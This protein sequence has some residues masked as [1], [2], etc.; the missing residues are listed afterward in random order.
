MEKELETYLSEVEKRLRSMP[1]SERIDVV[2]EL[3]SCMEELKL[4]EKKSASEIMTQLG[5]A[6]ELARQY[7]SNSISMNT[8]FNFRKLLMVIALYGLTGLSGMFIIPCCTVLA[9]GL[10][11][12]GTIA[13]IAGLIKMVGFILAIDMPYI[14][15]QI[16]SVALHPIIGFFVSIVMG[17]LFWILGIALWKFVI[18][19]IKSV[20]KV[21]KSIENT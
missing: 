17:I 18:Y 16:G 4:H 2:K 6:K 21:K 5:S 19:Y 20:G 11:V 9:A 1:T 8:K 13:P 7:L 3:K 12:S 10:A 14:S 15:I